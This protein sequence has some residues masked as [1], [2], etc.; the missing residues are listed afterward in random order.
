M[1]VRTR[2]CVSVNGGASLAPP[3]PPPPICRCCCCC[4]FSEEIRGRLHFTSSSQRH[5]PRIPTNY[6]VFEPPPTTTGGAAAAAASS[7]SHKHKR[8]SSSSRR[9]A[10]A[11]AAATQP[12]PPGSKP[13]S[14]RD[15]NLAELDPSAFATLLNERL[16]RVVEDRAAMER[17][18]R[19]MSEVS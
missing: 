5:T 1:A 2:V 7:S 9:P 13:I 4:C 14:V 19:L 16:Q 3:P 12:P 6:P 10:A 17:L 18:E 15:Q 11:A 8:G